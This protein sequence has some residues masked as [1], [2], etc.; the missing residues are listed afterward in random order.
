MGIYIWWKWN[1]FNQKSE[2]PLWWI[3]DFDFCQKY[4]EEKKS[5]HVHKFLAVNKYAEKTPKMTFR[6][7]RMEPNKNMHRLATYEGYGVHPIVETID[8]N[9]QFVLIL[10]SVM[11]M[12]KIF[13]KNILIL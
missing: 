4:H 12:K 5:S 10:N 1:G 3:E 6:P 9:V 11:F 13:S 2:I 8:I 7:Y